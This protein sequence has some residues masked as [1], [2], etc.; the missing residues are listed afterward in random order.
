MKPIVFNLFFLFCFFTAHSNT[1]SVIGKVVDENTGAPIEYASVFIANTTNGTYSD[2][3]GEFRLSSSQNGLLK[4]VVSHMS[5]Q[6]FSVNIPMNKVGLNVLVKLKTKIYELQS[7][8]IEDKDPYRKNKLEIFT[9]RLI[10]E[11]RNALNCKILNPSVLH[12]YGKYPQKNIV[13]YKLNVRADSSLIIEKN[14]VEYKLNVSADSLLIIKNEALGYTLKYDLVY[15]NLSSDSISF[16][17][18][19]LF[20]DWFDTGAG[21]KGVLKNRKIAY[22]GS[23]LHFFRS[24]FS[25]SLKEEGFEVHKLNA[26]Q[27]D[28]ADRKDYGLLQDLVYTGKS[29]VI[30]IQTKEQLNLYDYLTFDSISGTKILTIKEPFEIHYLK[31]GEEFRYNFYHNYF[32]GLKRTKDAQTTIVK[33]KKDYIRF[34]SNGSIENPDEIITV[35][36]WSFKQMADLLPHNYLPADK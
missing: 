11:S 24:L 8:N 4:L 6:T 27:K 13:E 30:S 9:K 3:N 26:Y 34:Y 32:V 10:G 15:F 16:Y 19:P 36:Y 35:G 18:Y 22:E 17:G 31:R 1:I 20:E 25:H 2:K 21:L 28:S 14:I 29:K 5:Y 12:L 23:K 7:V 33:L